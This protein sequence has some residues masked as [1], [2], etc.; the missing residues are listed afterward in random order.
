MS[1]FT[2]LEVVISILVVGIMMG[3]LVSLYIQSAARA[4][5]SA[6]SVAGQMMALR[7]VEQTRA[8]QWDPRAGV[9]VDELVSSN[10]PPVVDILDLGPNGAWTTYATNVTTIQTA[11]VSPPLKSIQVVCTWYFPARN[12]VFTN[13][14]ITFRSPDQ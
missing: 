3:G 9:P 4:E 10:F 11:S 8:A 6:Y 1:G 13:S 2:L 12:K 14:L 5:W 7:G